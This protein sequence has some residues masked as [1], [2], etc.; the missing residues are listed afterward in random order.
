MVTLKKIRFGDRYHLEEEESSRIR[1][2]QRSLNRS[3]SGRLW[4]TLKRFVEVLWIGWMA[5]NRAERDCPRLF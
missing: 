3:G 2:H 1:V 5:L 4:I